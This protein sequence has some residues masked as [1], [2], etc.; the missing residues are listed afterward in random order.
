MKS[1]VQSFDIRDCEEYYGI[2]ELE[3]LLKKNSK[4]KQVIELEDIQRSSSKVMMPGASIRGSKVG[5][6]SD[7]ESLIISDIA[8]D[9]DRIDLD[10]LLDPDV[11]MHGG[12]N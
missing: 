10:D 6:N 4:A 9:D 5:S 7:S 12:S 2:L 8:S 3:N 1:K 11:D